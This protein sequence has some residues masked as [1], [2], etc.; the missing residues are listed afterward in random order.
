MEMVIQCHGDLMIALTNTQNNLSEQ[1]GN[2]AAKKQA[3][4]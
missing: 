3:L 1:H 2:A 4:I